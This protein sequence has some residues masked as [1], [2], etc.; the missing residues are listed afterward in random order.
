[1]FLLTRLKPH[2]THG[3]PNAGPK[4]ARGQNFGLSETHLTTIISKTVTGEDKRH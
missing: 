3:P 4:R 1:M 2:Y